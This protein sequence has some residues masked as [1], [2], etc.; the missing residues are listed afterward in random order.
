L[1]L[2]TFD[3]VLQ[4]FSTV[5]VVEALYSRVKGISACG[6]EQMLV[7]CDKQNLGCNGGWPPNALNYIIEYGLSECKYNYVNVEQV[8]REVRSSFL[9]FDV[10]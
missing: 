3:V 9:F 10:F 7:D 2:S 6:S 5:A 4:A 8:S 1:K